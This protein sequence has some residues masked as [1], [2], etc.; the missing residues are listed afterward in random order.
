MAKLF[1]TENQKHKTPWIWLIIFP[2][3]SLYIYFMFVSKSDTNNLEGDDL[4]GYVIICAVFFVM[5]IGLTILFF[6]MKLTL[7]IKTD[8]VYIKFPPTLKKERFIS[9]AEISRYELIEFNR[10]R[11]MKGYRIKS[12][13]RQTG[14]AYTISGKYGLVIYLTNQ[15]KV[16]IDSN[17]KEALRS[18]MEKLMNLE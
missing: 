3:I 10:I 1:F 15:K 13:L 7:K 14:K 11:R 16:L 17:R 4:V 12:K 5:M 6:K 18:A 8:G 2:I 9:R